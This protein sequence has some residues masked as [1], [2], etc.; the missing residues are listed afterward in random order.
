MAWPVHKTP[1]RGAARWWR[2]CALPLALG[3]ALGCAGT[4]TGNPPANSAHDPTVVVL[5]PEVV[6]LDQPYY[7]AGAF[8]DAATLG[9]AFLHIRR[10]E[11]IPEG[12]CPD[13]ADIPFGPATAGVSIPLHGEAVISLPEGRYCGVRLWPAIAP[14]DDEDVPPLLAGHSFAFELEDSS[15]ATYVRV[16]SQSVQPLVLRAPDGAFEIAAGGAQARIASSAAMALLGLVYRDQLFPRDAYRRLFDTAI[17]TLPA[18]Q[19]FRLT[20]DALALA[21]ERG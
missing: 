16:R 10:I 5:P 13:D 11:L 19:A 6:S 15:G 8:Q 2:A 14:A 21:H 1:R 20:V 9:D 3:S 17:A 7:D 12:D 4:E 18:R